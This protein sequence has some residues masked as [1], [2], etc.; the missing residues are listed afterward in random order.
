MKPVKLKEDPQNLFK[1]KVLHSSGDY[2]SY[3]NVYWKNQISQNKSPSVESKVDS[4]P[5]SFSGGGALV[6]PY[7]RF[8]AAMDEAKK[9]SVLD[10]GV[11]V[12]VRPGRGRCGVAKDRF[13]A[14][15]TVL[16]RQPYQAVLHD[17]EL[18]SRC[19]WCM[20]APAPDAHLLRCS[21]CCKDHM[22]QTDHLSRF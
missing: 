19:S 6:R 2:F 7:R 3:F 20:K 13:A 16:S 21:R 10:E 12:E 14:G 4:T 5:P 9:Y 22:V 15:R 11:E 8:P 18:R 1:T 17:N